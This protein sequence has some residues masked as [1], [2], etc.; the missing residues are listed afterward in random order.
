MENGGSEKLNIVKLPMPDTQQRSGGPSKE[1]TNQGESAKTQLKR[2]VLWLPLQVQLPVLPP[3][4]DTHGR[5]A[6]MQNSR[7]AASPHPTTGKPNY[8]HLKN[9]ESA[10]LLKGAW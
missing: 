4:N 8:G 3:R 2:D 7:L 9:S 1:E 6:P 5:P 10:K